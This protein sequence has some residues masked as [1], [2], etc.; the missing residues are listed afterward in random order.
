M[1]RGDYILNIDVSAQEVEPNN[2]VAEAAGNTLPA[3]F[4]DAEFADTDPVDV[5]RLALLADHIYHVRTLKPDEGYGGE[6]TARLLSASDPSTNLLSETSAGYNTRYSGNLKLNIIPEASGDYF[7]E[8][9]S[10]GT[11]GAYR[12]GL[13]GRDISLLKDKGEPNN[14]VA[15]ADAMGAQAFD[16]PGEVTTYMLYNAAFPWDP[17]TDHLT[18]RWGAD[19][20]FYRYDLVEGDTLIAES[21]PADGPL[22]PRDYDGYMELYDAAGNQIDTNDDGGYDW[23][24]RIQHIADSDG[25]VY[26]MLRSQDINE[27][28]N[29]GGT[30][31]DPARGEYNLTVLKKDG[32]PVT[33][34]DTES[35][36]PDQFVLH[37]NYPNPF[38]PATTIAYS[39]PEAAD[40][41]LEI[42]DILGRRVTVL[43]SQIQ[44]QGRHTITFNAP[45]LASGIYFYRLQAGSFVETRKMMLIK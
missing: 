30:D 23:H 6:F 38:N 41:N 31:R 37:Q 43:V 40:V 20:D 4:I 36:I 1:N 29:G 19:V 28:A 7:L 18:A 11:A 42:Y 8:L 25:P 45:H 27:G 24:S 17:T 5:Y 12:I 16:L 13:K 39:L 44:H 22:W 9:T 32:T 15:E 10:D 14:S 33:V 2:S 21:S 35:A 34:T 3:G 26:V